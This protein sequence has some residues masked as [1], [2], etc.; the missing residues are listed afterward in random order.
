M[1]NTILEWFQ[2]FCENQE[3]LTYKKICTITKSPYYSGG[4]VKT[5]QIEYWKSIAEIEKIGTKYKFIS[6]KV[7]EIPIDTMKAKLSTAYEILLENLICA[8]LENSGGKINSVTIR[9]LMRRTGLVNKNYVECRYDSKEIDELIKTNILTTL[10][11]EEIGMVDLDLFFD[12]TETNYKRKIREALRSLENQCVIKVDEIIYK[13]VKKNG[14]SKRYDLTEEENSIKLDIMNDTLHKLGKQGMDELNG[15]ERSKFYFIWVK[16]LQEE[17]KCEHIGFKY[18][19]RVGNKAI[20]NKLDNVQKEIYQCVNEK[21]IT[22]LLERNNYMTFVDWF[23]NSETAQT[24]IHN[25]VKELKFSTRP[26]HQ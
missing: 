4:D 22:S 2:E 7:E 8:S 16:R 26:I 24:D 17:L 6:M 19:I 20:R 9:D 12:R 14:Y 3:E 23:I 13:V 1:N 15:K 25:K 18:D 10:Q 5:K 11:N 21:V